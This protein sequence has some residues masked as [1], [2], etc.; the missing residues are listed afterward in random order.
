MENEISKAVTELTELNEL[1]IQVSQKPLKDAID[2]ITQN[3]PDYLQAANA[4]GEEESDEDDERPGMKRKGPARR[5]SKQQ[6]AAL[7][8]IRKL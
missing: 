4:S 8:R 5:L 6:R 1:L 2:L 3:N 7:A